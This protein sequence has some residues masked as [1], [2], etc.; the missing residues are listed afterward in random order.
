MAYIA[1]VNSH[2]ILVYD[3][4]NDRSWRV[5][6]KLFYPCPAYGTYTIAGES[7]DLMDGVF[8]LALSP[9]TNTNNNNHHHHHNSKTSLPLAFNPY[10]PFGAPPHAG[11]H[12]STV[13]SIPFHFVLSF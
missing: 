11:Y 5:Q 2:S 7:F 3:H 12:Y 1:D 13:I 9:R 8:A 6:N 10:F 4:A